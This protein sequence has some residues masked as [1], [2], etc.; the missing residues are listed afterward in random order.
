MVRLALIAGFFLMV[1][2]L[3]SL[4]AGPGFLILALSFPGSI[5]LLVAIPVGLASLYSLCSRPK[6]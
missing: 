6:L 3:L 1:L 4:S 2:I 5:A